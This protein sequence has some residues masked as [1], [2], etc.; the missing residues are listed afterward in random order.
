MHDFDRYFC[1]IMAE[2]YPNRFQHSAQTDRIHNSP[3]VS[4]LPTIWDSLA[5]KNLTGRYYY[6]DV[7][8]LALWGSKYIN[9]SRPFENFITDCAQG[10]L[11]QVAYVDPVFSGET[12]EL[13][14]RSP[15]RRH[16]RRAGFSTSSLQ[17]RDEQPAVVEDRARHQL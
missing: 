1:S 17:S 16:T 2:T 11:P 8:F 6:G 14:R 9:I 3:T 12:Q 7:P 10:T 15:A 5:A 13:Q 4:T